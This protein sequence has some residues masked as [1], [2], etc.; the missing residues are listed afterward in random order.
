MP[1]RSVGDRIVQ[2]GVGPDDYRCEWWSFTNITPDSL[3]GLG[4]VLFDDGVTRFLE[5]E[6][7]ALLRTTY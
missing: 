1:G 4:E 5:Q 7:R 3:L 2:E 6:I